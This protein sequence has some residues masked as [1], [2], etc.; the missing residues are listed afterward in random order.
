M[1]VEDVVLA[2]AMGIMRVAREEVQISPAIK[3]TNLLG[4][5]F[6]GLGELISQL[7]RF[8]PVQ[9]ITAADL[10]KDQFFNCVQKRHYNKQ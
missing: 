6:K 3:I 10:L 4:Y 9:R 5:D 8:D 1:V 2:A 7:L